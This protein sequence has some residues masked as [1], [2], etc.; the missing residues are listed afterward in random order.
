MIKEVEA[1]LHL[2][3][4]SVGSRGG[5]TIDISSGSAAFDY[6]GSPVV[7]VSTQAS[8]YLPQR[9]ERF[10]PLGPKFQT[11][12]G[13]YLL[14]ETPHGVLA[15]GQT[16]HETSGGTIRV[17]V[18]GGMSTVR[19]SPKGAM[20]RYAPQPEG[21]KSETE[22]ARTIL[23][24][25]H[26]FDELLDASLKKWKRENKFPWTAILEFI[27]NMKRE[28][29]DPRMALIVRIAEAIHRQLPVTVEAARKVLVRERRILPAGRVI[30]TDTACLR[31]Y[32]RQPGATMAE[33]AAINHQALLG[34]TRRETYNTLENRILKD[35]LSRCVQESKRYM[36][37]E[38]GEDQTL[39]QSMRTIM[40][41]SF[42]HL[43]SNLRRAPFLVDVAK[44]RPGMQ[45]NYVLQNDSRYRQIW[46]FYVRLLRREDEEDKMWDWQ[47]RI[48]ADVARLLV[49]AALYEL[50]R[51]TQEGL[52]GELL[53]E[54][55]LTSGM[56]LSREQHQGCRV[57]AGS[58]PGPFVVR[59]REGEPSTAYVIEV[60]HP[61]LADEH[62]ATRD[63]GRMGGHL[64]LVLTPMAGGRRKVIVIWAVHTAAAERIPTWGK[65]GR[66]AKQALDR[67]T[68]LL[69]ER[70]ADFPEIY[71]FVVASDLL[72]NEA[73]LYAGSS[74]QLPLVQVATD[75]RCWG[76]AVVGLSLIVEDILRH[77]L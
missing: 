19:L 31:W 47:S 49:N 7:S 41:R 74:E 72:S 59:H 63:L 14:Y 33:K 64:Y 68:L 56:Q 5:E 66:S 76:D 9:N 43:C 42:R 65:I 44:P 55:F 32:V 51:S 12:H 1:Q 25:S 6:Y 8:L 26:L 36:D 10:S 21:R 54:E 77:I 45:P 60:V 22:L 62:V 16:R 52:Q 61:D 34:I 18:P 13:E 11:L 40:V 30:E 28:A 71:G 75:Q 3:P 39:M 23:A 57:Q 2:W 24:W 27:E 46:Q 69:G 20:P 70:I 15:S 53:L 67:H 38:V 50:A 4:W 17:R 58:E 73:E 37:T 29:K 35:F 48:W